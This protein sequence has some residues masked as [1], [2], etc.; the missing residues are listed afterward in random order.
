MAPQTLRTRGIRGSAVLES[1]PVILLLVGFM[2]A[3]LSAGYF[4][5]SRAELQFHSE[6][7]L[8]CLAQGRSSIQCEREWKDRV[9]SILPFGEIASAR[10]QS[11]REEWS[12]EMIWRWQGYE[13]KIHKRL[14]IKDIAANRVLRW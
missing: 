7:G 8:Y 9:R 4:V 12:A 5:F 14:S 2:L 3:I 1:I 10:L 13:L 6:R 11:G